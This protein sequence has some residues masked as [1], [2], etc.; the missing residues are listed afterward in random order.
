MKKQI[1]TR[2]FRPRSIIEERLN[3]CIK[4]N[5]AFDVLLAIINS[6]GSDNADKLEYNITVPD[7]TEIL[8]CDEAKQAYRILHNGFVALRDHSITFRYGPF[9]GVSLGFVRKVFYDKK[10]HQLIIILEPELKAALIQAKEEE[11]TTF[12]NSMYSLALPGLYPPKLYYLLK[13]WENKGTRIDTV[14]EL[15]YKLAYPE[16]RGYGVFKKDLSSWIS[17]INNTTDL[18]VSFNEDGNRGRGNKVEHITF[19]I[20][21]KEISK[22]REN[23]PIL[24]SIKEVISSHAETINLKLSPTVIKSMASKAV[25]SNIDPTTIKRRM[26]YISSI[27]KSRTNFNGSLVQAMSEKFKEKNSD[28]EENKSNGHTNFSST[29]SHKREYDWNKISEDF[30]KNK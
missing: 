15:R 16:G 9:K 26:S 25:E 27:A 13:E 8:G 29:I 14:E 12:Y 22:E 23:A 30:V 5:I 17:E 4:E 11:P 20:S 10:E 1:K 21:R 24:E 18:I 3:M 7:Y 19:I 28:I 6:E 2:S